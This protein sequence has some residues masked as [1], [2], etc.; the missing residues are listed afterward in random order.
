MTTKTQ[1]PA[2]TLGALIWTSLTFGGAATALAQEPVKPAD[3]KPEAKGEWRPPRIFVVDVEAIWKNSLLG[4]RLATQLQ[5]Q[6]NEI[7]SLGN[8]KNTELQ[9][10]SAEI[11]AME[12]ELQKQ[13]GVLSPEVVEKRTRDINKKKRDAQDFLEE[14]QQE[15]DKL[16]QSLQ[17]QDA[18]LKAEFLQKINP[19]IESVSKEKKVD[20]LLH[21]QAVLLPAGRDFDLSQE[22]IVKIDDEERAGRGKEAP[23]K[24]GD[25]PAAKPP[26]AP[27]PSPSPKP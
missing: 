17:E 1:V 22:I 21:S 23:A 18:R 25:K 13:A 4:K 9:K 27:T 6:Q 7:S 12:E 11:K 10:L 15:I 24:P 3:A 5:S 20:I 26:A 8:K 14:G 19:H 2:L 16:R